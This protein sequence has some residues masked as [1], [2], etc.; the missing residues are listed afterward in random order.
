MTGTAVN[1]RLEAVTDISAPTRNIGEL[2]IGLNPAA[3]IRGCLTSPS[4]KQQCNEG[5]RGHL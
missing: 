2:G 4:F 5:Q 3:R 1:G